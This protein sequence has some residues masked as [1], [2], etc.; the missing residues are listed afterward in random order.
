MP[1]GMIFWM[2]VI[3]AVIFGFFGFWPRPGGSQPFWAAGA[4]YG[5]LLVLVLLLG[6]GIYGWPIK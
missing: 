6:L 3:L 4:G 5:F 2:L 1:V